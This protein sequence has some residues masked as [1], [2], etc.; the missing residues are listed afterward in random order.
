MTALTIT[1]IIT[2]TPTRSRAYM[3]YLLMIEV[4]SFILLLLA[5]W[6]IPCYGA[7]FRGEPFACFTFGLVLTVTTALQKWLGDDD[8]LLG[9]RLELGVLGYTGATNIAGYFHAL[10]YRHQARHTLQ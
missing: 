4:S 9:L 5:G 1:I 8:P 10:V 3:P 6:L 2:G 7:V